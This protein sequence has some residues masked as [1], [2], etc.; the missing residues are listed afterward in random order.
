MILHTLTFYL[1]A[2]ITVASGFLVIAVRN[3]V[4]SVLFLILAFFTS[5]GL[6][7]L[8]GAEFLAMILVV[9]YVGAVAVLFLFVVMMLDINF[10][11]LRSGFLQYLPVGVLVGLILLVELVLVLLAGISTPHL[12]GGGMEPI[13]DLAARTNTAALGDVIYTKYVYLFQ[14]AG[15]ILLIAMI[16][17]IV[18]TLRKRPDVRRQQIAHQVSRRPEE[19]IELKKVQPGQGV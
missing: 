3:P 4:H 13:P 17:A 10:V 12:A 7:V 18:L 16:G 5:A 14:A 2:A 15:M 9:V 1:L 19:T 6:F 8:I 11:E